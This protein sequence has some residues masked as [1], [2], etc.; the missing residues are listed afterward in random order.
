MLKRRKTEA[1]FLKKINKPENVK[2]N[3]RNPKGGIIPSTLT[4]A[5]QTKEKS[6]Q[7][8]VHATS[9]VRLRYSRYF[10]CESKSVL[11]AAGSEEPI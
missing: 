10:A 6:K 11:N 2:L 9:V 1:D 8:R 7:S 4:A 3:T 5:L